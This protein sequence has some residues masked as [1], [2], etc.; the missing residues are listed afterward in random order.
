MVVSKQE[1]VKSRN[2]RANGDC[3]LTTDLGFMHLVV[4]GH[5]RRVTDH[6]GLREASRA[7]REVFGWPTEVVGAELDTEYGAPTS[8]GP[9]F[10][11]YELRPRKAFGFPASDDFEPTRW[12][13][14]A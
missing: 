9:P 2:L 11:V 7:M 12:R 5:A 14:P 13:F 1:T 3:T 8:G 4:E 10:G 6:E